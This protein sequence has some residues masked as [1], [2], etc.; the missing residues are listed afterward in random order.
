MFI[1]QFPATAKTPGRKK[2][3]KALNHNMDDMIGNYVK[4]NELCD[5]FQ[6]GRV[7][8]RCEE[9]RRMSFNDVAREELLLYGWDECAKKRRITQAEEKEMLKRHGSENGCYVSI[10]VERCRF[11]PLIK[12]PCIETRMSEI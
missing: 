7:H 12:G 1:N 8:H 4:A 11:C 2:K 3:K 10:V 9:D 6:G 5:A